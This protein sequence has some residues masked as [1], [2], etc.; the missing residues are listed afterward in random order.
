MRGATC[1][2]VTTN[3]CFDLIHCRANCLR[4]LRYQGTDVWRLV[5]AN[6]DD[7]APVDVNSPRMP[8]EVRGAGAGVLCVCAVGVSCLSQYATVAIFAYH[9]R[10]RQLAS[11]AQGVASP[12]ASLKNSKCKKLTPLGHCSRAHLHPA[13]RARISHK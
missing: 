11:H 12:L 9:A 7:I 13:I 8:R 10:G 4:G 6:V 5:Q 1:N 3:D 2:A